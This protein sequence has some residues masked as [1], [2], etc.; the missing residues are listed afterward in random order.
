MTTT[1]SLR[2]PSLRRASDGVALVIT[3]AMIVLLTALLISFFSAVTATRKTQ[4]ARSGGTSATLLAQGALAAI[5][6]DLRAEIRENSTPVTVGSPALTFHR[7]KTTA[8]M[9]P[10]RALPSAVGLADEDFLNLV[11]QSG[12][13]FSSAAAIFD[14]AATNNSST[15]APNKRVVS[16]A[17]WTAPMLTGAPFAASQTPRWIYVNSDGYSATAGATTIGRVAFNVYDVGGLLDANVAGFGAIN[18]GQT[19]PTEVRTKGDAVWADLRV[20]PG[21]A[22]TAFSSAGVAARTAWPPGWR[23][24]GDWGDFDVNSAARLHYERSGW[25]RPFVTAGGAAS[26]RMFASR[27]DLVRYARA[28]PGTFVA[29]ADGTLPA[30]QY[31]TTF[32]R[33]L[34][35]PSHEPDPDRPKV[36]A[37]SPSGGNDANGLDNDL[38]PSLLTEVKGDGTL[39]I[40]RRFPLSRLELVATPIPPANPVASGT[41]IREFFG[42]EWNPAA[43]RWIYDHGDAADILPLVDVP[44]DRDPDFFELL[45][46]AITVGS[47][48]KQLGVTFPGAHVGLADLPARLG[49]VDGSVNYQIVQIAANIIDQ[50]DADSYPTRINFDGRDF[51]G[52]ED[53]PGLYRVRERNFLIGTIPGFG[54]RPNDASPPYAQSLLQVLML[55]PTVWNPHSPSTG[56]GGDAPTEFRIVADT[57]TPV[58]YE[59]QYFWP[60]VVPP[61]SRPP[62]AWTSDFSARP[63]GPNC[64][65]P[66]SYSGGEGGLSG[67]ASASITFQADSSAFRQPV[68]LASPG[69]PS[70]S[71]AVGFPNSPD[72]GVSDAAAPGVP[73]TTVSVQTIV[74]RQTP[75][76]ANVAHDAPAPSPRAEALGFVA[77]YLPAGPQYGMPPSLAY[78]LNLRRPQ[79]GPVSFSLQY[80]QGSSDTWWTFDRLSQSLAANEQSAAQI[81]AWMTDRIDPRTDR[82]GSWYSLVAANVPQYEN[83]VY[84][85]ELTANP[86]PGA[87]PAFLARDPAGAAATGWSGLATGAQ[88][89]SLQRNGPSDSLRYADPDGVRRGGTAKFAVDG[90]SPGWPMH[91]GNTMSRPTILDRPFRSVAELGN[92]F[93]GTPWRNLDF[94]TPASGDRALLDVFRVGEGPDD[95]LVA[96]RVNLNT[97]QE[98]VIAALVAGA[99][100]VG[101]AQIDESTALDMAAVLTEFTASTDAGKGPLRDRSELVGRFVSGTNFVG[102]V[103]DDDDL[104]ADLLDGSDQPIERNRDVV[105]AA[106]A[107]AGTVRAWNFLVDIIAQSGRV[108]DSGDFIPTGES[109]LW[110]SFAIDRFTNQTLDQ[111]TEISLE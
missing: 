75:V 79:G 32:S 61:G 99:G 4:V 8:D 59:A 85:F 93:R 78:Y 69:H 41:D 42:L 80:R 107:D 6:G 101:G 39:A 76:P 87:F 110:H 1:C 23:L 51:Y 45:K 65:R 35:R 30:L 96:G 55:Q 25:R 103:S 111:T 108:S 27:Q 89:G 109:R 106:L 104:M 52:Q 90:S 20:L 37:D 105:M 68:A 24:T 64:D 12:E 86:V 43:N 102:V 92:A 19:E 17:R 95:A 82:W 36:G 9:R 40:K 56:I 47:L 70:G 66:I 83:Y 14:F 7:P 63:N 62:V 94:M 58:R 71:N 15:A 77:G 74:N 10:V 97:R 21:I 16:P 81:Q 28:F 84:N 91:E 53:L 73:D 34:D 49:G 31:L 54:P 3:L 72:M 2:P 88:F 57:V 18:G 50:A 98:P 100:L 11:K 60:A 44:A 38:N 46:A 29:N 48:G 5:S 26:D 67:L 13:P 22:A 33:D